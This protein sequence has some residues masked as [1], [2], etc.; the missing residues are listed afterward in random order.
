MEVKPD[1]SNW[2]L[3]FIGFIGLAL[4]IIV[5]MVASIYRAQKATDKDLSK[6]QIHVA[7]TYATKHDIRELGE[8]MERQMKDGFENLKQLLTRN[9]DAA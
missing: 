1:V 4:T 8:R 6:H 7:E 2:I 9:K 5:P 3:V